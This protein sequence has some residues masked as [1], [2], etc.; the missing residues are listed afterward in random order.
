MRATHRENLA[1][2]ARI[3][4]GGVAELVEGGGL[5]KENR[6]FAIR[7]KIRLNPFVSGKIA[8]IY[9]FWTCPLFAALRYS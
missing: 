7:K 2:Y 5:E 9:I 8:R 1:G 4:H 6:R 3:T